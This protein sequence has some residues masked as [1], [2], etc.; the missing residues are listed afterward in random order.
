MRIVGRYISW[1]YFLLHDLCSPFSI[2]E[3]PSC[4]VVLQG[5]CCSDR[6]W[7]GTWP[8]EALQ[9]GEFRE[10]EGDYPGWKLSRKETSTDQGKT[11]GELW[12]L[13]PQLSLTSNNDTAGNIPAY[14]GCFHH[15]QGQSYASAFPGTWLPCS[16]HLLSC[17]KCL[18][19]RENCSPFVSLI[20][21]VRYFS[22]CG[23]LSSCDNCCC[24]AGTCCD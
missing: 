16:D 3:L 8:I 6:K 1:E 15:F 17:D 21:A 14:Y 10:L 22:H 5:G 9:H 2:Q 19:R 18:A 12:P 23:I 24:A 7:K 4:T 13:G 20:F 11:P